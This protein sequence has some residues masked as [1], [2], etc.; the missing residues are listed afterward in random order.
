MDSQGHIRTVLNTDADDL[1][2][3]PGFN[4]PWLKVE[5]IKPRHAEKPES[6]VLSANGERYR[7]TRGQRRKARKVQ[8]QSRKKNR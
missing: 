6:F 5:D 8:K 7:N 1:T 2:T 4:D 3:Y